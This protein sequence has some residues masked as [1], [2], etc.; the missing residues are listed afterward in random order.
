[1][2]TYALLGNA[3]T[4]F[5]LSN[6]CYGYPLARR[7]LLHDSGSIRSRAKSAT[8]IVFRNWPEKRNL[9]RERT[10]TG[11]VVSCW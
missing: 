2:Q 4:R 6:G 11:G 10:H 7:L 5:P 1:M 3:I 9:E 8:I